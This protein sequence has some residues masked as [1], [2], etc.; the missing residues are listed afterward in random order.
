VPQDT[1]SINIDKCI[2]SDKLDGKTTD[3]LFAEIA[4]AREHYPL[5]REVHFNFGTL[6]FVSVSGLAWLISILCGLAKE[7]YILQI[8]APESSE[9]CDWLEVMQFFDYCR[10]RGITVDGYT[11]QGLVEADSEDVLLEVT[12][13]ASSSDV[14]RVT[15]AVIGRLAQILQNHLGYDDRDVHNVSSAISEACHNICDHSGGDGVVMAQRHT[16]K[17]GIPFV[18]IGVAD[19]GIGIRKS[20]CRSHPEM[21]SCTHEHAIRSALQKGIS[22]RAEED[23]GLGLPHILHIVHNYNGRLQIRSGDTRL[24]L[25]DPLTD[26][27]TAYPSAPFL[28]TQLCLSLAGRIPR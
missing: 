27:L 14:S 23:R 22:G 3:G 13:I 19:A 4:K 28:G 21:A 20:L 24:S 17:I 8:A 12:P 10:E 5:C 25:V 1:L 6:E 18:V 2:E 11:P 16:S 7:G 26:Q 9:V 15:Y